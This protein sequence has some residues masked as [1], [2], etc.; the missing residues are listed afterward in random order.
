MNGQQEL[1]EKIKALIEA[2]KYRIRIHAVRHM[3]EEG[4]AERNIIEALTGRNRI[5]E[6]Y[7]DE[8]RCL[9]SGYFK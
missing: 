2:K 9:I 5:L 6:Y 3:I 7:S 1:L 8:L 4:F